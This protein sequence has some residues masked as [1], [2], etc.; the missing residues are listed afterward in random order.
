MTTYAKVKDGTV[1]DLILAE[2]DFIDSLPKEEN[3]EWVETDLDTHNNK[4]Y[5][6]DGLPDGGKPFRGHSAVIGGIYDKEK[7][8]F[9]EAKPGIDWTLDEYYNWQPP[10]PYPDMPEDLA[11]YTWNDDLYQKDKTRG[12]VEHKSYI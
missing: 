11:Y 9:C 4:H 2:Q 5:G 7:D 3:L 8:I 1:V 12:W 10:I 6:T